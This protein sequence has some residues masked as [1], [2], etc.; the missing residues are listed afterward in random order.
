MDTARNEGEQL[1]IDLKAATIRAA[2]ALA[3]IIGCAVNLELD[4]IHHLDQSR[5]KEFI[6]DTFGTTGTVVQIRFSGGLLGSAN[7]LL[8][9]DNKNEIIRI[10]SEQ[11][12]NLVHNTIAQNAVIIEI[13]NIVLNMYAGTILNQ[14]KVKVVYE[15]PKLSSNSESIELL[16]ENESERNKKQ[17]FQ[18]LT[19]HLS[20]CGQA[21]AIYIL[22]K[23]YPFDI[24]KS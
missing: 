13:A 1:N 7:F 15:I 3:E 24:A 14:M 8:P 16:A 12:P 20:I 6:K 5:F 23:F 22:V 2:D 11:D 10:L 17:N 19:S 9:G 18:I 4:Q 21:I